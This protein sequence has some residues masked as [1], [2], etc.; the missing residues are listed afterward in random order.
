MTRR[1]PGLRTRAISCTYF[2]L[3][4][5]CSPDSHPHTKSNELSGYD[6]LSAS[7][8]SKLALVMP[9]RLQDGAGRV[10]FE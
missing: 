6:M 1:P 2:S 7:T 8:S 10:I 4:G 5:M 3:S 9:L